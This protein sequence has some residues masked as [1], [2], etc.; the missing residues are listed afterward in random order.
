MRG[1]IIGH[2]FTEG[3]NHE[4]HI[5][6]QRLRPGATTTS[7][8]QVQDLVAKARIA[9]AVFESFSQAQVDVIVRAS[10]CVYDNARC[11]ANGRR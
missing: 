1:I 2:R 5:C 10:A 6:R 3:T 8:N 11:R 7:N 4:H 9:Q